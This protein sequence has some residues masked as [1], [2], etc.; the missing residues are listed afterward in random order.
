MRMMD[1]DRYNTKYK[2]LTYDNYKKNNWIS[3][4]KVHMTYKKSISK[5][6]IHER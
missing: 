6:F 2:G 5:R 3:N 1:I 4:Q